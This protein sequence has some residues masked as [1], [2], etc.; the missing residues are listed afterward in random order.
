MQDPIDQLV[1]AAQ[2][3][4]R[5]ND[6]LWDNSSSAY[7]RAREPMIESL[8]QYRSEPDAISLDELRTTDV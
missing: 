6:Y 7:H 8:D 2:E 4:L 1:V 3:L 5:T